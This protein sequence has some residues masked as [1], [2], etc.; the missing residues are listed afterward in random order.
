MEFARSD[1]WTADRPALCTR[2]LC[3]LVLA[4]I[5][6]YAGVVV[7]APGDLDPGFGDHGRVQL[8]FDG[9]EDWYV[10]R[11][12]PAIVQQ[13]D[14]RVLVA[15]T[16]RAGSEGMDSEVAVAR[17]LPDGTLDPEFG[18]GGFVR[19][20]F[21]GAEAAGV[22]GITL[23][24]D[25]R[26]V[27]VGYS[28]KTWLDGFMGQYPDLDTGLALVRTDGSLDPDGFGNGGKLA[29]DLSAAGRSDYAVATVALEDGR[30]VV[31]GTTE[32]SSGSRFFM[33]RMTTQGNLDPSFGERDGFA[34][35]GSI[36]QPSGLHRTA[37]GQFVACGTWLS[38]TA[39]EGYIARFDSAGDLVGETSLASTG[40]EYLTACT[41]G[42][43]GS[44]VVGGYGRTGTWLGRVS[45]DGR[46]DSAFGEQ[47]GR[48]P[49]G[50]VSCGIWD[51]LGYP[52]VPTGIAI[53]A[54]G[55]LTVALDGFGWGHLAMLRIAPDGRMDTGS[56][57]WMTDRFYD[58]GWRELSPSA[59]ASKLLP[60]KEGD[61]LAVV[62]GSNNTT[63]LRLKGADGPGASVIGLL[64][65]FTQ[66]SESD[67]RGLLVCRSGSIEG[68]VSVNAATR[69]DTAQSP[70]DYVSFSSVVSWGDGETGCKEIPITVKVDDRSEPIESL[71]VELTNAVG[72]GLGMDKA[73]LYIA[74]V[75]APAPPPAAA[76]AP[77]PEPATRGDSNRGGGGAAGSVLLVMLSALACRRRRA[78]RL[79]HGIETEDE[80][81]R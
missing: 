10:V 58:M 73:R 26:L 40:I 34:R 13:S 19:L 63:V 32:G 7:A 2:W 79:D 80:G 35:A 15:R 36:T 20:R 66:Q 62:A 16:D 56:P 53:S 5:G 17:L 42:K 24:P 81:M 27:V 44:V 39:P 1:R 30:I 49:I 21:R 6:M 46:L 41:P 54:D 59:G 23:L 75:Q 11:A 3:L 33:V 57:R 25:G 64:G 70:D 37:S 68:V 31:A 28:I 74:D 76:P 9:G 78:Q 47:S 18:T 48:T 71:W 8:P 69:D 43:D 72:A 12:G 51:G 14:G 60:T 55:R 52:A 67:S 65:E 4:G 22:G 45:V 38:S 50:C 29:L 61:Q 77:A